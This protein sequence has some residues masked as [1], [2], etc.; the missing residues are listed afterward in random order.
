M[1]WTR[2]LA[3]RRSLWSAPRWPVLWLFVS[4]STV[5]RMNQ[6]AWSAGIS[7]QTFDTAT[8][9]SGKSF[10]RQVG[11]KQRVSFESLSAS[12]RIVLQNS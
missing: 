11:R 10:D 8:C 9:S 4:N 2:S 5:L 7:L 1:G 12:P 3:S 6:G